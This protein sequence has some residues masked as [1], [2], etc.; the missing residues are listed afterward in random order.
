MNKLITLVLITLIS[1]PSFAIE[2]VTCKKLWWKLTVEGKPA[3][4]RGTVKAGS[5][6]VIHIEVRK[7]YGKRL[8][9]DWGRFRTVGLAKG[10]PNPGGSWEINVW[11]DLKIDQDNRV[12]FF[13][14][15]YTNDEKRMGVIIENLEQELRHHKRL[16]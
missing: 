10:F 1:S 4:Y 2:T 12:K 6:D 3:T 14:E 13:C 15:K 7:Y 9:K 16:H 5:A 8:A 11:G